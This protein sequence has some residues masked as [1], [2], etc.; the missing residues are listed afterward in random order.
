MKNLIGFCVFFFLSVQLF[1]THIRGGEITYRRITGYNYEATVSLYVEANTMV[2]PELVDPFRWGDG[3]SEV[4]KL[5]SETLLPG[6]ILRKRVYIGYHTYQ[7]SGIFNLSLTDYNRVGQIN[8]I[9]GGASSNT[10]F[11]IESELI[12]NPFN[13]DKNDSPV[14]TNPPL[15]NACFNAIFEHNPGAVDKD[16]DSLSYEL[17]AC[18]GKVGEDIGYVFPSQINPGPNNIIVMDPVTGTVHWESPQKLGLY[19]IAFRITEYRNGV[20]VGSLVRDMQIEVGTCN[21]RVPTIDPLPDTCVLANNEV[22]RQI[23]VNDP[24]GDRVFLSVFGRPFLHSIPPARF[25]TATKVF[26]WTPGCDQVLLPPEKITIR[27]ED[28]KARPMTDYS[29]FSITTIAPAVPNVT[30]VQRTNGVQVSWGASP[31]SQATCYK[32]YR[33]TAKTSFSNGPCQTGPDPADQLIGEVGKI[34]NFLDTTFNYQFQAC[35]RVVAC[36]A[37]GALSQVSQQVCTE[38]TSTILKASVFQTGVTNG[39]DSV[40]WTKPWFK[41][42]DTTSA[43]PPYEV[44]LYSKS[45]AGKGLAQN[46]IK[47]DA[48][49]LVFQRVYNQY[50]TVDTTFIHNNIDT[51]DSLYVYRAELYSNGNLVGATPNGSTTFLTAVP[52]DRENLLTWVSK[53]PWANRVYYIQTR[54]SSATAW[55]NLASIQAATG[56]DAGTSYLDTMLTNGTSYCYRVIGIGMLSSTNQVFPLT[57]N[58]SQEVCSTPKDLSAPCEPAFS[59]TPFCEQEYNEINWDNT[60][61]QCNADIKEWRLFYTPTENGEFTLLKSFSP[62][63]NH[64]IHK[65]E[66]RSIAGCYVMGTVDFNGNESTIKRDMSSCVDNCPAYI[67]PNVFTP[68][69]DGLNDLFVPFPYHGVQ[70]IDAKI[71]NRWGKLLYETTDP[72]LKWDGKAGGKLVPDGV[73]FYTVEVNKITLKGIVSETLKGTV[74]LFSEPKKD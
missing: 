40:M 61:V 2:P 29:T 50:Y 36:F 52:N 30:L 58:V 26:S 15:D 8:N 41:A 18:R 27:A 6:G 14:L 35:Y 34:N 7:G 71:Y 5:S 23:R 22:T 4:F 55:S 25:D 24:D 46:D 17:I 48:M 67:L 66:N 60:I 20:K 37:N 19:S 65:P 42:I 47:G 21:N 31:C 64:Y 45:F 70:S 3:S 10:P 59:V 33:N 51:Q 11:Y 32:I 69:G 53:R 1:A 57:F 43:R 63:E 49:S 44:R 74:T 72:D 9:K 12:I 28:S 39:A 56:G 68:N 16:G 62:S 13:L 38:P 73:Y 54:Q